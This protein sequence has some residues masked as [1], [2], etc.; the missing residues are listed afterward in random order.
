L[1]N[2]GQ[3]DSDAAGGKEGT[4]G[5]DIHVAPLWQR[6]VTGS[7]DIVVA[8]IDTGMDRT[9]PDLMPNLYVNPGEA[10][11]LA[12]NGVDDDGNGFVDDVSGWNFYAK[13]NNSND[14]NR[15]GSH[16][17]GTIGAAGNNGVGVV[18]VNW[19]VSLLP[20]KFLSGSGS[21][22]TEG[23]VNA[24]NYATRMKV[25]VMSNSW[26]GG[27]PSQALK[28]AI[29]KANQAGILFVAAAGN[30]GSNNVRANTEVSRKRGGA[31]CSK[32][33]NSCCSALTFCWSNRESSCDRVSNC[34]RIT[35][36]ATIKW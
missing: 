4:P 21:G 9:H 25:N 28:E 34:G 7:R 29:E 11:A 30:D 35:Y 15:H 17:S 13:N 2:T 19:N 27:A 10:G 31:G 24:V 22:S 33:L 5:S 1:V 6:G 12:N 18:G 26:G 16:C 36:L 32:I 3:K 23:A 14:D 8:V 20:V